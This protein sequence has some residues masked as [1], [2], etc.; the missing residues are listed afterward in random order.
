M[1]RVLSNSDVSRATFDV[2]EFEGRWLESFGRPELRGV[3]TVFGTSGSGKT[4]FALMLCKY[5]AQFRRTLYDSM[6]QGLSRSMQLS[7][8]R[9]DMKAAGRGIVFGNMIPFEELK[10]RLR[11][12]KSPQI[13]LIDSVTALQG[14]RR[15]DFAELVRLFP[16]KLFVFIAHEKNGKAHPAVAEYIRCLSDVKIRVEGYTAY[17]TSRFADAEV[18]EGGKNFVIWAEGAERYNLQN[19]KGYDKKKRDE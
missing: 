15:S 8:M 5:L 19:L 16:Q 11:K 6:E 9:V 2:A 10:V 4:T 7:W 18:G 12:P 1:K 14:F 17:V 3:W 13:V